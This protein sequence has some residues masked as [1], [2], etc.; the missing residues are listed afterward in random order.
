MVSLLKAWWGDHATEEVVGV[1]EK[2]KSG[3]FGENEEDRKAFMPYRTSR[4][5]APLR[6]F[7]L[8]II[9]GKQGKLNDAVAEIEAVLRQ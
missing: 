8:M 6:D 4:K 3:F 1:V 7:L 2:R 5:V 9:Q